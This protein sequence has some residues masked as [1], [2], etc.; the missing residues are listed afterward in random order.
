MEIRRLQPKDAPDVCKVHSA[1]V[2][3][4]EGGPY[5][6]DILDA[7]TGAVSPDAFRLGLIEGRIGGYAAVIRGDLAGFAL[8]D[9]CYVRAVYIRPEHQRTGVAS[10]L[11]ARLEVDAVRNGI[12]VFYLE[13]SLNARKFYESKGF[14][15]TKEGAFR[16][17]DEVEMACLYMEKQLPSDGGEPS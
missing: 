8:M 9:G 15:V 7:W 10:A 2:I 1:A 12:S 6:K 17:N 14:Y 13:A 3:A 16:L 4:L 5:G 11:L